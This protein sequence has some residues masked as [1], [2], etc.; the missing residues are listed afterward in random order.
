LQKRLVWRGTRTSRAGEPSLYRNPTDKGGSAATRKKMGEKNRIHAQKGHL[1]TAGGEKIVIKEK[2]KKRMDIWGDP[3]NGWTGRGRRSKSR[4][5]GGC[6]KKRQRGRKK[7][8]KELVGGPKSVSTPAKRKNGGEVV[9]ET[10]KKGNKRE[11]KSRQ[12]SGRE[13]G[14]QN[15]GSPT[16]G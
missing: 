6:G 12:P 3:K 13:K 7:E 4:G 1:T 14:K 9:R 16:E 2:R 10:L 15:E 8:K 11:E 5:G